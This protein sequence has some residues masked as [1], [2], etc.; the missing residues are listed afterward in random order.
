M[1]KQTPKHKRASTKSK[2]TH[3]STPQSAHSTSTPPV[4]HNSPINSKSI[5]TKLPQQTILSTSKRSLSTSTSSIHRKPR[6]PHHLTPPSSQPQLILPIPSNPHLSS[7]THAIKTHPLSFSTRFAHSIPNPIFAITKNIHINPLHT[8]SQIRTM[9]PDQFDENI[10][11]DYSDPKTLNP[12]RRLGPEPGI[13]G[14]RGIKTPNDLDSLY[15][16]KVHQIQARGNRLLL[17]PTSVD[18]LQQIDDIS[19]LLCD[20][21]DLSEALRVNHKIGQWSRKSHS[22]HHDVQELLTTW[23][24]SPIV[25]LTLYNILRTKELWEPLSLEGRRVVLDLIGRMNMNTIIGAQD[26]EQI[27]PKVYQAEEV[28]ATLSSEG[29]VD[30]VNIPTVV[31]ETLSND[32]KHMISRWSKQFKFRPIRPSFLPSSESSNQS[33]TSQG[34]SQDNTSPDSKPL[35]KDLRNMLKFGSKEKQQSS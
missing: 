22:I 3:S 16:D 5:Y 29:S 23:S 15:L 9:F 30:W 21:A 26:Y 4:H 25:L 11:F 13:W 33:D 14:L 18:S 31:A 10:G 34:S 7:S 8:S 24:S 20:I 28:Y 27:P 6:K 35:F 12:P 19:K 17:Q 1:N 2:R 32:D